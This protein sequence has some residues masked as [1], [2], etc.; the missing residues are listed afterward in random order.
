MAIV[1]ACSSTVEAYAA[2]G[3]A[4]EVPRP[5]CPSCLAAMAFWSGY[6]R[7]VRVGAS[8]QVWVRRARCSSCESS[9]ALLPSFCLVGRRFG[10]EVI[11]PAVA[12]HVAGTGS[13]SLAR[14]A[15]VEQWTVRSWCARHRQ[16]AQ[17]AV[18]LLV[19]L[20][21][22][23]QTLG[24]VAVETTIFAVLVALVCE[25]E[26]ATDPGRWPSV[27]LVTQGRWLEPLSPTRSRA[28]A[29]VFSRR[30]MAGSH[31]RSEERPP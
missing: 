23:L 11:G 30:F 24:A 10:V 2:A 14:A 7:H 25:L 1:W 17:A 21:C 5:L 9:H 29:A 16:R 27:S 8:W 18:G 12:G 28:Y 6:W 19:S 22:S 31:R 13:R 20:G 15:G 26:D 4:V 3:K